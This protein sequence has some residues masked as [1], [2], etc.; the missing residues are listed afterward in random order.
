MGLM[1]EEDLPP[2]K[3]RQWATSQLHVI[4]SPPASKDDAELSSKSGQ[5]SSHRG[6]HNQLDVTH[7][8]GASG[9]HSRSPGGQRQ[10]IASAHKKHHKRSREKGHNYHEEFEPGIVSF[11]RTQS[12]PAPR[13][14]G[15]ERGSAGEIA[16][17]SVIISPQSSRNGDLDRGDESGSVGGGPMG[18]GLTGDDGLSD[19]SHSFGDDDSDLGVGVDNGEDQ[20]GDIDHNADTADSRR[21]SLSLP[22]PRDLLLGMGKGIDTI[23]AETQSS[24]LTSQSKPHSP[25]SEVPLPHEDGNLEGAKQLTKDSEFRT[26]RADNKQVL[27]PVR[28]IS[29]AE[30]ES[31]VSKARSVLSDSQISSIH[32]S[33]LNKKSPVVAKSD[34]KHPVQK[35][36][37]PQLRDRLVYSRQDQG[38]NP[39]NKRDPSLHDDPIEDYETPPSDGALKL[40]GARLAETARQQ[41]PSF[42]SPKRPQIPLSDIISSSIS[43]H[44]DNMERDGQFDMGG[45][46]AFQTESHQVR[47]AS[48]PM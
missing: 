37:D 10:Q 44:I 6:D 22:S 36:I 16:K 46:D 43:A 33:S 29:P 30:F 23:I 35:R 28:V 41:P 8:T 39:D 14:D 12:Q 19:H 13:Q 40:R 11:S 5:S 2:Q 42:A 45:N 1:T 7:P 9:R 38:P 18:R 25:A 31:Y 4:S 34:A 32:S 47:L 24:V 17:R 27:G 21:R 48:L 15:F 26:S 3:K 20:M